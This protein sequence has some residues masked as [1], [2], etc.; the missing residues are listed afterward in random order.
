MTR[1]RLAAV[2]LVAAAAPRV[3][4]AGDL[5]EAVAGIGVSAIIF[6][7][8]LVIVLGA[9][10]ARYRE[11]RERQETI[12]LAIEKG[13]AIPAELVAGARGEVSPDRDL[14]RGIRHIFTG[15]GVGVLLW[16]LSPYRNVWAVGAMIAIFGLGHLLSWALTRRSAKPVPPAP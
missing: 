4:M 12:R 14:H 2:S 15:I 16:F 8:V 11:T 6:G 9:F 3:A 1:T 5:S 10:Y 13:A 7:F